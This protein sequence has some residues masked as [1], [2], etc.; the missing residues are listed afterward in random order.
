MSNANT[1]QLRRVIESQHGGRAAFRRSL[2][3]LPPKAK[4]SAEWDGVVHIFDLQDHPKSKRAYAWSTAI[5]GGTKPRYFA[6]LHMGYVTGPAQ[7]VV[8]AIRAIRDPAN[9]NRRS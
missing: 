6:V 5:K 4:A 3:V 1:E 9:R 7:A 8:A 2:R